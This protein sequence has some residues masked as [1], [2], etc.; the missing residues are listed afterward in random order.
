MA[1]YRV[2]MAFYVEAD[3]AENARLIAEDGISAKLAANYDFMIADRIG[4][5]ED[6]DHD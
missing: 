6:W 2:E 4:P 5:P 3:S 1:E